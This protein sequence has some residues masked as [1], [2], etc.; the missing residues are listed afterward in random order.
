MIKF[1]KILLLLFAY[2]QTVNSQDKIELKNAGELSGRVIDGQNVREA[3]GNVEFVQGNVKVY[4]NSALQYLDANRVELRGNVRLYQDT[5]TLQTSE[6]TYFGDDKKAICTGGV[7]LKDPNA[8]LRADNGIYSFDD[9]KAIFTGDV[10]IVN[11]EYRITSSELTYFRG[12]ED[13]FARGNVIVTTDSAVIKADNI[14]FYKMQGKTFAAGNVRIE[15]DSTVIISD[16]ATNYSKEK[17]SY[18]SGN[19]SI[20]SLN[21]NTVIFGNSIENYEN[22]NYTILMGNARLMQVEENGDTLHIY[23]D[24]MQAYRSKPDYYIAKSNVEIIRN[25]FLSRCR[26][27]IYYKEDETISL[28][29]QPIVWQE[30]I[31]MTGDSIYAELPNNKLQTIYVKKL[32]L[33]NSVN[34]FVISENKDL[35]FKDRYDQISGTDVTIKFKEDKINSIEVTKN[36]NSIY[37]VYEDNKANGM[38]KIEG[39]EIYIYFDEKE[40]P[41][42]IKVDKDPKG[43]YVPE[44][45]LGTTSL[46]LPGFDL[47]EDKPVVR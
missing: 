39:E 23:S 20:E 37:F 1:F 11:P 10:I 6:A 16:T 35:Y 9:G 41:S 21:N 19:V 8:V 46:T 18:A 38:N 3:I 25:E 26:Y 34:S 22:E 30:N 36:S 43:E 2:I 27:G 33:E 44:Q 29:G 17:K 32:P 24:T 7:T 42:K 12:N 13:S 4:C 40:K 45:L 14:D 47:R 31:Q 5:L 15:S 28:S